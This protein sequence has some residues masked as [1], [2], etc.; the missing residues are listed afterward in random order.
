MMKKT[1]V[2]ASLLTCLLLASCTPKTPSSNST[3]STPNS[4]SSASVPDGSGSAST[5]DPAGSA[6]SS[7]PD[8][9]G[10][11]SDSS[12]SSGSS[13]QPSQP[14]T[15]KRD[16]IPF[17][18]GQSYA[19]A[20]LGYLEMEDLDYY[21]QRYLDSSD[22]PIHYLSSGDY[23][24]IIPRYEGME[25]SLY[26]NDFNTSD[27]T[28]FYQETDCQPFIIQCNV[29]DIFP[30]ATIELTYQG[31]TVSF[32]PFISLKDGSLDIGEH[33]L[34]LTKPTASNAASE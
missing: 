7:A 6:S 5:P 33:G 15:S 28:L 16:Q 1:L 13:S 18:E 34:D 20:H 2:F 27:S 24:L 8:V 25:L 22:V 31:K 29:S 30:D 4:N 9:S 26:T 17:T 19:V 12:N 32:S 14:K 10:N 3:S 23:Y 11:P 21:V